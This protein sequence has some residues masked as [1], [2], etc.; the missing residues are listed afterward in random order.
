MWLEVKDGNLIARELFRRHYSYNRRRDQM[1]M[2]WAKE[3]NRN[4]IVGPGEKMVLLTVDGGALFAWR[5]FKSCDGQVGV[6][7]CVF[8]RESG[9]QASDMIRAADALAWGRWPGERLYTYVDPDEVESSNPGYCF[10]MAGYRRCGVTKKNK[11]LIFEKLPKGFYEPSNQTNPASIQ[12]RCP[13]ISL[14][15]WGA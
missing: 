2:W 3:R 10:I 5:K 11:L 8:R 9:P 15:L 4:L 6:N 14:P 12:S 7:C 1:S 13:H